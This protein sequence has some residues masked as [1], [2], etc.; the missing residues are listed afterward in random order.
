MFS[1]LP[2]DMEGYVIQPTR[3][4]IKEGRVL[5]PHGFSSTGWFRM[6]R[7]VQN[8]VNMREY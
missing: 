6:E 7:I 1:K 5:L 4:K 3:E 2:V 8:Q